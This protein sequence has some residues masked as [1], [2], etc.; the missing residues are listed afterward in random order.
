L[1]Q[2]KQKEKMQLWEKVYEKVNSGNGSITY[3][4][5]R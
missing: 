1:T 4:L 2:K 5:V 3:L